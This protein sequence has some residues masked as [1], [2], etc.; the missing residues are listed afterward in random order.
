MTSSVKHF[1]SCVAVSDEETQKD[2][3][4]DVPVF[5]VVQKASQAAIMEYALEKQQ[6]TVQ[7]ECS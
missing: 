4:I 1:C 3:A 2:V 5:E 6:Q 7:S